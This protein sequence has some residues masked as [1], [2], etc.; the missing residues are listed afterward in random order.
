MSA[1]KRLAL[2]ELE[3]WKRKAAACDEALEYLRGRAYSQ[4]AQEVERILRAA[5]EDAV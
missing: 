2:K 5:C 4:E 3:T 1:V